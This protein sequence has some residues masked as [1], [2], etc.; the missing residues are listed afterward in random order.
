MPERQGRKGSEAEIGKGGFVFMLDY[1]YLF[2]T[3]ILLGYLT[4]AA[5]CAICLFAI[6]NQ[7]IRSRMFVYTSCI[8]SAIAM[9]IRLAYNLS[10]IDFGFHTIVIWMIFIVVAIGFCRF[11]VMQSTLSILISGIIIAVAEIL[12]GLCF[13]L[14]IGND[15]FNEIMNNTKTVEGKIMKSICG[16]PANLFFLLVVIVLYFVLKKKRQKSAAKASESAEFEAI[17]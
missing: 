13:V 9:V 7:D 11:P 1:I 17:V 12:T 10:L 2:I 3:D 16:I 6:T 14:A 5:G 15:A 4:Q 8:Y